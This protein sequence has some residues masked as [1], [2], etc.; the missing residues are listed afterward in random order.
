MKKYQPL[1]TIIRLLTLLL[2]FPVIVSGQDDFEYHIKAAH[3]VNL[4]QFISWGDKAKPQT[5]VTICLLGDDPFADTLD[6][7]V[8]EFNQINDHAIKIQ[9][10][11]TLNRTKFCQMVF[12]SQSEQAELSIILKH[13]ADYRILTISEIERFNEYGGMVEFINYQ[14][15][16][17]FLINQKALEQV[18]LKAHA[19]LLAIAKNLRKQLEQ[20]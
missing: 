5:N 19:R 8:E 3:L 10:I 18:G 9:R 14:G 12:I 17:G 11:Q 16:V 7:T 20:R 6:I 2:S 13:L 15:K 4:T 1:C